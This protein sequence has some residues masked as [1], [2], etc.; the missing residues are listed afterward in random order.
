MLVRYFVFKSASFKG[1]L[2]DAILRM[3]VGSTLIAWRMLSVRLEY[4]RICFPQESLVISLRKYFSWTSLH[5]MSFSCSSEFLNVWYS[6][7]QMRWKIYLPTTNCWTMEMLLSIN[8]AS[9]CQGEMESIV[10]VL[11]GQIKQTSSIFRRNAHGELFSK[12]VK[13]WFFSIAFS[14]MNC[15]NNGRTILEFANS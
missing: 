6:F 3:G 12:F 8:S 9:F 14:I 11:K 13:I 4:I 1:L 2:E 10:S 5:R 7:L 15:R